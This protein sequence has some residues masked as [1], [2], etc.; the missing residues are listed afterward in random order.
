MATDVG[1]VLNTRTFGR[2]FWKY[3]LNFSR[4]PV[5]FERLTFK[6]SYLKKHNS[7]NFD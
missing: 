7:Y 4:N 3:A 2:Q 5:G 1:F 6:A